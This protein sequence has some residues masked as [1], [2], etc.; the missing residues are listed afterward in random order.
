MSV[1]VYQDSNFKIYKARD[2]FILHNT[3]MEFNSGH[4]HIQKFKTC[5]VIIKLI[6][7]KQIPKSHSKHFLNSILRV[8]SD[9]IYSTV[10]KNI[11]Q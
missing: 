5:M 6:V 2:G 3:K 8:C 1:Q 7:K 9:N 4:T 10:I 11:L